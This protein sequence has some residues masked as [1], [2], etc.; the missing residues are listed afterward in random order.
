MA[1]FR[2]AWVPERTGMDWDEAARIGV[3][4]VER[5]SVQQGRPALLMTVREEQP[6]A[7]QPRDFRHAPRLDDPSVQ[8]PHLRRARSAGAGLCPG[9]ENSAGRCRLCPR[10]L[11]LCDRRLRDTVVAR[12]RATGAIDLL[13]GSA[14]EALQPELTE[15]LERLHFY[16]NNG[17]T[18]GFGQDQARR[19]LKDLRN[20]GLLDKTVITGDMLAR[21]HH[22]ESVK[23]LAELID[24]V[25]AGR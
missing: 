20:T 17:W 3:A 18:R 12:A 4:W 14:T 19:V 5:E 7:R 21:E 22:A 11:A 23:R 1:D 9:R 13:G 24:K 16:G 2:A 10:L 8:L 6:R 25:V 15:A